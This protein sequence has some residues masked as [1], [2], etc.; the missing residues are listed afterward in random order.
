MTTTVFQDGQI[1]YAANMNGAFANSVNVAGDAMTGPLSISSIDI[2]S[3]LVQA[4]ANANSALNLTQSAFA[5]ANSNANRVT[6]AYANANAAFAEANAFQSIINSVFTL[7]NSTTNLVTSAYNQANNV[8]IP[9][10]NNVTTSITLALANAG[11]IIEVNSASAVIVTIPNN[12]S[13]PF[14]GNTIIELCQIGAG[15]ITVANGTGVTTIWPSSNTTRALNST[16][17]M[18]K[19]SANNW[20]LSGDLT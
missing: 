14:L 4:K 20:I 6:G 11:T 1:L 15:Q 9:S 2:G 3:G 13:V 18:R 7:A 8:T 16:I 17:G 12:G 19:R 10:T 5:L